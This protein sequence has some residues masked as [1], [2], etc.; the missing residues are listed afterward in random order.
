VT[1]LYW[2]PLDDG[3]GQTLKDLQQAGTATWRELVACAG[4]RLDFVQTNKLDRIVRQRFPAGPPPEVGAQDRLRL[5]V[6]GSSTTD[7]LLPGLRVGAL[8]RG[9]WLDLWQGDYGLYFSQ[10]ADPPEALRAFAPTSVLLT[11]DSRHLAAG[12]DLRAGEAAA[13]DHLRW[14]GD[15]LR[16]AW[17]MAREK[18]GAGVLQ[19]TLLPVLP[20]LVGSNEHRLA[21]SP[22]AFVNALNEALRAAADEERVDLVAIDQQCARYGLAAWYDPRL[23]HRA[24]QEIAPG[25]TPL[26]GDLVARLLAAKAGRSRKCLVLDLDNTLWGGVIGDDGLERIVLGQGHAVGEAYVDLQIAVRALAQRGVILAV[27]SKNDEAN[28][29]LPFDS[30]PEMVL[31]RGDIA[32]FVANWNDKAANLREIAA[33]LNIG[34]DSLVFLDDNPFERNLVRR[35]LP[36]VAVPEVP[37][38]AAFYAQTLADAGYFESTSLSE[39]DFAR[40]AQ[41]QANAQRSSALAEHSDMAGYLASLDMRLLWSPFDE[42]NLTRIVQLTNKTNQFNLTT[43]RTTEEEVRARMAAPDKLTL[44]F[45]LLDRFGDNGIIALVE[46]SLAGDTLTVDSWLMSCR[47]LK[48]EVERATLQ[49]LAEEAKRMGATRLVGLYR[50]TA[51]NAMVADHYRTLGFT[52]L[53]D[54]A[55]GGSAWTLHLQDLVPADLPLQITRT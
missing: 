25:A 27:C 33:R 37:D 17:R 34:I 13:R 47:V 48:R 31:K 32:C 6:L 35:E 42:L 45:R 52:H 55:E 20:G 5:A 36:E 4:S 40:G 3:L 10:L 28:A 1:D 16:Q 29:W 51:K 2:L 18:L 26:Y 23:W 41:Y 11:L 50:P 12:L 43:R 53:S 19:Q 24:K 44:Q 30:H 21:G 8:R 7:H 38:D 46:G 14:T 39:E 15:R 54:D 49:V 9:L 22:A